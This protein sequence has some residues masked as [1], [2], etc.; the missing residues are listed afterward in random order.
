VARRKEGAATATINRETSALSRMCHIGVELG[1][2]T[3]VPNLTWDE[4]DRDGGCDSTQPASI[5]N[6]ARTGASDLPGARRGVRSA[7]P[8]RRKGSQLVFSPRSRH[9]AR[10]R[11]AW[12]DAFKAA[13]LPKRLLH[14]CRRTAARNLIRAGVPERAAMTLA[15]HKT[16][17]VFDWYNIVNERELLTAGEQ[18][19]AYLSRRPSSTSG[20]K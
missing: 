16:R 15:G 10:G 19:V 7:G 13:K 3:S 18:L 11:R 6:T 14:D 20:T 9:R 2:L 5:K 1:W 4:I 17:A 12:L 8:K